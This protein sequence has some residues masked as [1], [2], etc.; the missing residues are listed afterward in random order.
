MISRCK[1]NETMQAAE[2]VLVQTGGVNMNTWIVGNAPVGHYNMIFPEPI[3]DEEK[4]VERLGEKTFFMRARIMAGQANLH[5][6]KFGLTDFRWLTKD[7]VV[8]HVQ[9][10]Y[11]NGIRHMLSER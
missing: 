4:K 10:D 1:L 11:W 3:V 6:N 2:R 8:K 5:Q 9:P 7:E